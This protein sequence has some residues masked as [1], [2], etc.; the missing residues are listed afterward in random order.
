MVLGT[1]ALIAPAALAHHSFAMYER[2]KTIYTVG[3]R[4]GISSGRA[5]HVSI[6][7]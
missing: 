2:D 3:N 4:K 6:Q 1:A 5:R 7:Y